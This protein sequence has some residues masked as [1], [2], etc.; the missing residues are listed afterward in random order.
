MLSGFQDK[1][2]PYQKRTRDEEKLEDIKFFP[3]NFNNR[4][5]KDKIVA[6]GVAIR[7]GDTMFES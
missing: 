6:L 7:E 4:R 3:M 2:C 5:E 1:Y